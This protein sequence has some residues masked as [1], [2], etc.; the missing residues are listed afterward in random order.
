MRITRRREKGGEIE[1]KGMKGRGTRKDTETRRKRD[2]TRRTGTK[3]GKRETGKGGE[4][5]GRGGGTRK[6]KKE[7][8]IG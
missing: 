5:N 6:A 2:T 8:E 1:G 7:K 4:K 3:E